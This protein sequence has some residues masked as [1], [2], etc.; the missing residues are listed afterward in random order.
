LLERDPGLAGQQAEE[1]LRVIPGQPQAMVILAAALRRGG[2]SDAAETCLR[3]LICQFPGWWVGQFQLGQTLAIAGKAQPALHALRRAAAAAPDQ[4]DCWQALGDHCRLLGLSTEA[5]LCNDRQIKASIQNP[6]LFAAADLLCKNQ[7]GLAERALKSYLKRHPTDFVAIRML[8]ELASRLGRSEDSETLL[9]RCLE[10]APNFRP[11]LQNYAFVLQRQNKPL[12]AL[13][14]LEG[15]LAQEPDDPNLRVTKAAALVQIGNYAEAI[16]L[17]DGVLRHY[18]NQPRLWMSYG[19][20]LKT[21]NRGTAAIAAYRRSIA[22]LPTLGESYWSLANLKTFRF[23]PADIAAMEKQIARADLLDDDRLHF[24][25]ALGK[26]F[27]DLGR[28][29]ESFDQYQR[30]NLLRRKQIAYDPEDT[31]GKIDQTIALFDRPFLARHQGSGCH[32]PD[33]IFVVGLPRSGS[34]LIEQILAS[35]SQIEGTMELPDLH[36]IVKA[37][38]GR[39]KRGDPSLYPAVLTELDAARLR[40]LGEDYLKRTRIQRKTGR[41]FFIDKMP[42]NFLHAG[43]IHLMLPNA[44]I[45]D[46]RRH[47]MGACF[48]VFK[49]HFA[50]GQAFSYDLADVGRYY[51]DY[52]RLMAH[53]DAVLPGRIHRVH[54]EAM[55]TDT[56]AEITRLLDYC[57]LSLEPACLSFWQTKRSVR[58]ASS[59]QVRQPIFT[60][61]VDHWRHFNEWLG[62]LGVALGETVTNYPFQIKEDGEVTRSF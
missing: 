56:E 58:T 39:K 60:D 31:A 2:R 28:F 42:N 13:A 4:N 32:D 41:P 20:A 26:A 47:P 16:A 53:F 1:I 30:G 45:I 27:E 5:E 55:V 54:Y 61:G 43:L 24:H 14:V 59:E 10:L 9:A 12:E 50:R 17:Y 18:P 21:E 11:A 33:P 40:E 46:A 38:N 51:A 22:Q 48:S 3:R 44:K 8:A 37:L 29:A 49:Q 52:V 7:L 36:A 25:F 34:T 35:H 57:G 6:E 19:H 15:P 62:P 23:E